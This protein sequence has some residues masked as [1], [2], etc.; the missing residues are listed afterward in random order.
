MRARAI[1]YR[2]G[3]DLYLVDGDRVVGIPRSTKIE[4]L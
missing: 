4:V 2:L 3:W 1:R